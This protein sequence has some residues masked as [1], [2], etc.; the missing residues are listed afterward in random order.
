MLPI[1]LGKYHGNLPQ[2]WAELQENQPLFMYT[3]RLFGRAMPED[4]LKL[5]VALTALGVPRWRWYPVKF[6]G[7]WFEF[8]CEDAATL[9][10]EKMDFLT[11]KAPEPLVVNMF[12]SLGR[13]RGLTNIWGE[14]ET[15]EWGEMERHF[16]AVPDKPERI[17]Q[18]MAAWYRPYRRGKRP[19]FELPRPED[20]AFFSKIPDWKKHI[21]WLFILH[22]RA[23][24]PEIFPNLF[25]KSGSGEGSEKMTW[26]ETII[27][28]SA[29]GD[30]TK[31]ARVPIGTTLMRLEL[32]IKENKAFNKPIRH[33]NQGL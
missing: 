4:A 26:S 33:E 7:W 23:Q 3:M 29:P 13:Y 25:E 2:T 18:F 8:V 24:M 20:V 15:W 11:E 1:R 12:P 5:S 17:N 28:L 30:E 32:K 21:V 10:I 6:L 31:T 9:L 22:I 19:E 14:M 16:L 27:S